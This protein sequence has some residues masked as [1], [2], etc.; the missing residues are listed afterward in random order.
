MASVFDNED[1]QQSLT[2]TA[3]DVVRQI[4]SLRQSQSDGEIFQQIIEVFDALIKKS[5]L[6]E[7]ASC[8]GGCSFCCHDKIIVSPMEINHIKA[9]IERNGI[10]PNADRLAKQKENDPNIKWIDKACPLLAEPN[11]KGERFCMI[12]DDRPLVCRSHNSFEEPK[13]CN[14]SQ[15][16]D[17]G[18]QEGRA[19]E[20]D[21]LAMALIMVDIPKHQVSYNIA[22]HDIL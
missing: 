16:P 17:R 1:Y 6:F 4:K 15:Y 11:E 18:I 22:L 13:F 9:V 7:K 21:A 19:V 10:I 8:K 2:L 5:K 20:L 14:K 12:Y 3:Y